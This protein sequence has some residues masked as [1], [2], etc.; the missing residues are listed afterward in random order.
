MLDVRTAPFGAPS[1]TFSSPETGSTTLK[2]DSFASLDTFARR[3]IGP[4]RDEIAAM[5]KRTGYKTIDDLV[6]A[7][8]PKAIRLRRPLDLPAPRGERDALEALRKIFSNNKVMRSFIGLGYY[9][10]ATPSVIQRNIL[11]NPGWYTAYTPYQA[12]IAQGRLEALLNFQTMVADLTGLDIANA[13][14]LDEATACRRGD[15]HAPRRAQVN[16]GFAPLFCFGHMPSADARCRP[17]TRAIAQGIEVVV[18]DA[19]EFNPDSSYFGASAPVSRYRPARSSTIP[20]SSRGL[21]HQ[22]GG[23]VAMATRICSRSRCSSP[24]ANSARI[25]PSVPRSVSA[26]R[27]ATAGRTL[28]SSRRRTSSSAETCRAGSSASR[29][30]RRASPAMRLALQTR[31][32]HIRRDK[33]TSNI[34]T[35]QVLLAVMAS[36]YAVYHGPAGLRAIAQRVFT[37]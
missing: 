24:R 37:T 35:A 17:K 9:D 22:V 15:D 20:S 25:L 33:A 6:D 18:D 1:S 30:T 19:L 8:V 11:E 12:E 32:Q 4:Q 7:T 26:C 28:G 3:H 13:S 27:S 5:L 29:T 34:C 10:T 21:V 36:M 2:N 23:K 16:S 31:E 14:L